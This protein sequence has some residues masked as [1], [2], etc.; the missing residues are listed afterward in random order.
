M[1][2]VPALYEGAIALVMPSYGGP[3]NFPPLEAVVLCCPVVCCDLPGCREQMR[4]AALCWRPS[5]CCIALT[6]A[7]SITTFNA[8][9]G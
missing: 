6:E 5:V 1:S 2:H 7:K 8:C 4:D 3:T 9:T